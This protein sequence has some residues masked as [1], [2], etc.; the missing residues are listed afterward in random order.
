MQTKTNTNTN[1]NTQKLASL[2]IALL[3]IFNFGTITVF[4]GNGDGTGGGGG[5]NP[6]NLVSVRYSTGS[7]Y[8]DLDEDASFSA[9]ASIT[10]YIRFD[11]GMTTYASTNFT[12]ITLSDGTTTY[13]LNLQ[14][15]STDITDGVE[16]IEKK[17]LYSFS[18]TNLDEG[19][20]TLTLG[21]NIRANNG[22][23]LSNA[24]VV[25]CFTVE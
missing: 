8:D 1:T 17:H 22:Q 15:A 7:G 16:T 11:R 23:Y 24:P 9:P 18:V 21:S 6:L 5:N 25:I 20:Y 12:Y 3:M 2:L 13:N 19:E 4:A 10:G 14:Q